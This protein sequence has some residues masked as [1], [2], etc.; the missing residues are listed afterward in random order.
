MK[1]EK[2]LNF[3]CVFQRDTFAVFDVIDPLPANRVYNLNHLQ[4]MLKKEEP[5]AVTGRRRSSSVPGLTRQDSG[6]S[7][8]DISEN[9]L[10]NNIHN[11]PFSVNVDIHVS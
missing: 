10:A 9:R 5:N 11:S 2:K 1:Q 3:V 4:T 6:E 8:L 7:N